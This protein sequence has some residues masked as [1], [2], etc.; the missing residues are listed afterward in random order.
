MSPDIYLLIYII[1]L[2]KNRY[3]KRKSDLYIKEIKRAYVSIVLGEIDDSTLEEFEQEK[4]LGWRLTMNNELLTLLKYMVASNSKSE[5]KDQLIDLFV[6]DE[7]ISQ[8][9][10]KKYF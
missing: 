9:V 1:V 6:K 7:I 5:F 3:H 2:N 8:D 10:V 4:S